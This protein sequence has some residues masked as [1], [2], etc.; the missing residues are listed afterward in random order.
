VEEHEDGFSIEGVKQLRGASIKTYGDHRIA[1]AFSVAALVAQG[2]S[3]IDDP[4]CV[5]VSYPDFY[6]DLRSL[7]EYS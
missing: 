1:M 3:L 4:T 2:E 5:R 6:R 7:I